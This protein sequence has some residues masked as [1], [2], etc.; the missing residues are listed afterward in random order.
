MTARNPRPAP[1]VSL[2]VLALSIALAACGSVAPTPS[3]PPDA[4]TNVSTAPGPG[5]VTV[6]WD[7]P[8]ARVSH[9]VVQREDVDTGETTQLALRSVEVGA[10]QRRYHDLDAELG[11]TY[12]Y[13]VVAVGEEGASEP[14]R[15][16]DARI[17]PGVDLLVGTNDRRYDDGIGTAFVVYY[18]LPSDVL[19]DPDASV[20]VTIGGPAGWNDGGAVEFGLGPSSPG[21]TDG[22]SLV[23]RN[24]V[25][26]VAGTYALAV[27]VTR[28]GAAETYTAE[29]TLTDAS[30]KLGPAT[31]VVVDV[32]PAGGVAVSWS[33]PSGTLSSVVSLWR[34][35]YERLVATHRFVAGTSYVF[36]GVALDDGVHQ[37][38]VAPV[39]VDLSGYPI[40]TEPFGLAYDAK[41]FAVG[42]IASPACTAPDQ[43]VA[44]PDGALDAAIRTRLATPSGDLTCTD[45]ALLGWLVADE[46]GIATLEGLQY[47]TNLSYLSLWGNDVSDLT[48]LAGLTGL[49]GLNVDRNPLDGTDALAGLVELTYLSVGGTG[50]T[51]LGVV[52]AMTELE[53]LYAWSNA[54]DDLSP[55]AGL[56]RLELV[57]VSDN[58]LSDVAPVATLA[59]LRRLVVSWNPL[60]DVS[61]VAGLTDLREL[62]LAGVGLVDAAFVAE[63]ASLEVL[64]LGHN[65]LTSLVPLVQAAGLRAGSFVE[66]RHN[67]LD[68]D[69]PAV[70]A[71]IQALLDR[72]VTLAYE[73]QSEE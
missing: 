4:P 26:A 61:P 30:F 31:D 8:G 15:G 22:F 62:R 41:A 54:I 1:A 12:A 58:Q 18:V 17:E 56:E 44:V 45:L 49:T 10:A 68:L 21:R 71:S 5:Y 40:K 28:D 47:A 27:T 48:P 73:P 23:S 2:T 50:I 16:G 37:V 3:G 9:F 20:Q 63:L 19:T 46:A 69:D 34:G 6:A 39:N 72:G 57:D 60:V 53:L 24:T 42:D 35:D 38:E 36:E 59:S 43:R 14:A 51:D 32:T 67:R 33:P 55:L 70:Q 66:A 7:H 13:G 25:D 11:V 65:E 52:A 64:D 29:A